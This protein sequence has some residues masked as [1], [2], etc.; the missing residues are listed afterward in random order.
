MPLD[1]PWYD[2]NP[3][4]ERAESL[5]ASASRFC[6]LYGG[7]RS[8][9]TFFTVWWI[10]SR[11]LIAPYSKHLIVRQ[12]GSAARAAIM[13]GSMA[14]ISVVLRTCFPGLTVEN[15]EKFGY[16]T[17]PNGSEIWVGGLNDDKAMERI[18][19]NE[20]ATIYINEASEVRYSAFTLLRSRLAQVV[21]DTDGDVLAQKFFVDLNPT[22]RAH[23]TYRLWIDGTD[24]EDN[25][26]VKLDQYGFEVINP[27]D[28]LANLSGDYIADLEALPARARKRFLSG[29]YIEDV[30]AALW[31]RR[32]LKR[33]Q[34]LPDLQRINVSIDP[35]ISTD[36]GSDETGITC[37][38]IDAAGNGY[39]LAD[40]SG[41]YR[42]EEWARKAIALYD[43]YDA[44]RIVAE[45]NQGGDMV[46]AV[47]R[48]V[49][50]DVPYTAVTATRGKYTRAEPVASLYERGKVFH[51]GDFDTLEDQMCSFTSDFD[52]KAQGYS[53]D[54][55]DALVWGFTDLFPQMTRRKSTHDGP[56]VRKIGTLA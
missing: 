16:I 37:Q 5:Y 49:R 25:A 18:L 50:A 33:V 51:N 23:W 2:L 14:T 12:E 22:T 35:A 21:K 46:E 27:Y 4:Q 3:G 20:Y 26:P 45:K 34:K 8:G 39:L 41:K 54:R 48:S 17:L 10:I 13:R 6:L 7:S 31:Q 56:I 40:D 11:A 42:P 47:I 30:E 38:G 19:G 44:D 15:N 36:P 9:K 52:R 43:F 53:P 1:G 24:P 55:V 29:E 28:N 32:M